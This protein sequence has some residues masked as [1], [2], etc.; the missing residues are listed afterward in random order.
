MDLAGVRVISF[1]CYGTLID[2]EAGLLQALAPWRTRAGV[3]L[4]D[5]AL[6]ARFAGLESDQQAATPAL[7]Y[8]E[9]L[10]VVGRRLGDALA[11][12]M[13][14]AEALAFGA[15]VPGWPAFADTVDALARLKRR[16]RLIVLSNVDEAGFLGSQRR[17]GTLFDAVLTAEAIGSYKP[18]PCNFAYLLGWVRAHGFGKADLL[19]AAQSLFHDHVPA[20]AAGL[21]TAWVDRYH[22]KPGT[23]ATAPAAPVTPDLRVTG[24]AELADRLGA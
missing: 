6:L 10:A 22:A 19:H 3:A 13:T 16:F 4:D 5:A 2:W 9:L 15:S 21:T 14:A 20:K 24:L 1:D 12:P 8:R 18:S 17:L 23:G 7:P 11:A